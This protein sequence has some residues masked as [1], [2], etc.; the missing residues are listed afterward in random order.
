METTL[1]LSPMSERI[2]CTVPF[3]AG[4]AIKR[5]ALA[6]QLNMSDR[7]MRKAIQA[8]R[9]EGVIVLNM[10]DGHGYYQ[11]ANLG[12]L[13]AQYRQDTARAMAILQRRK[14]LRKILKEAGKEV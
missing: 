5:D 1:A 3:G 14:S 10:Q 9:E 12:E 6:A 11:S 13:E 7:Q 8:A 4:N 2:A